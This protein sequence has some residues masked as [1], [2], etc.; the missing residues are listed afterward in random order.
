MN[1]ID[2]THDSRLRRALQ[3]EYLS[4]K[5]SNGPFTLWF[6]LW[7]GDA[8]KCHVDVIKQ[9]HGYDADYRITFNSTRK[10]LLFEMKYSEYL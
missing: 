1:Y 2:I 8:F 4:A 10:K 7:L 9:V 6:A 5:Q 3:P